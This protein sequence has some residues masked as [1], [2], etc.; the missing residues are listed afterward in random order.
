MEGTS[1]RKECG[2]DSYA[3]CGVRCALLLVIFYSNHE[4]CQSVPYRCSSMFIRVCIVRCRSFYW[5]TNTHTRTTM[6]R[7]T[8][9][10]IS[11]LFCSFL[12]HFI[13]LM[14]DN[15]SRKTLTAYHHQ[16][17]QN[18]IA[19]VHFQIKMTNEM[20]S[21][22]FFVVAWCMETNLGSYSRSHNNWSGGFEY[23]I[24]ILTN[25]ND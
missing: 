15:G 20:R 3:V 18:A 6:L 9:D 2:D 5:L 13:L 11:Y 22:L 7:A 24:A 23:H 4:I 10:R 21:F 14:I 17:H 1:W 19:C 16:H 25:D 12:F 8:R